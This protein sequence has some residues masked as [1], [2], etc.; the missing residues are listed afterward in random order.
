MTTPSLTST[1]TTS[2]DATPASGQPLFGTVLVANRGEIA[3]RV[4]R[5]LR[6]LGIRSV[7]V[8]SDADAGARHVREAD[9]AVRIGPAAATESYLKIGNIIAAC[10]ESGAEAVHPGYGFLS[11]NADFARALDAAGIAFMGPGVE[12]LNIMGDKIRSKNHVA[13]YG[14]PVVP[15][16]ARPGMTDAELIEAAP[17]VGFP[18]LIKPSAGG[19]GKGMHVVEK[20][21][22]L[23]A[24]LA[25]ARRVAASAFGDDT[26]F[27]ERLVTTPRHIEV[28]VL[29]DSHGNVIHLGERECSLQRRHQKVIEE[30][31][32]P[33]LEGLPHGADVRD[34]IGE[35]ACNA[36]RSVNYTGAGTVEFLVSDDAPDEFFFM[37]MNTRLQVE[38]PVTEMVTGLDLVE[39]QVRIAAGAELTVRQADVELSGHAVEA[40]V[41]AEVPEK[42]FLPSTGTVYLLDELPGDAGGRIRVDSSLV[43]G[44]QLSSS[45]D[46][47]LSKVIAWGADRAEALDTLDRALAG[48]TALGVDTNVEYLRL[49]VNDPEVRAGRLDTGLIARKLP[50]LAFRQVGEVELV[51]A[52]LA[53][54]AVTAASAKAAS[55]TRESN[56]SG[57][58]WQARSGWRLGAPAP[59]RV[60]LGTPDGGVATIALYGDPASG[61]VEV[62]VDGGTRH[63]AVLRLSGPGHAELTLDDAV[64]GFSVAPAPEAPAHIYLGNGGWSCRLE[65]L[66]RE[67][68]LERV[69]AA[70]QRDEGDADPAVRSPMP[71]TVVS[72][73]VKDG[74]AV[75]AGQVLASVEAMK[76]EHQLVAPLAGTVHLA[77]K[78]GDLVKADQVL[79]TI[80]PA[81]RSENTRDNSTNGETTNGEGAQ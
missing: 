52:A 6:A 1:A 31:P 60:S 77:A 24:V 63:T 30:A 41:Y 36:A 29:A 3:C 9:T 17:A 45:Y 22:D 61:P 15:G 33:L 56:S 81:P 14:V 4:I 46:P 2:A 11:E 55:A 71:G 37:E 73:P 67:A 23:P 21:G 78:P 75:E 32:S 54:V 16:V 34:R 76:M 53:S 80:H 62:T 65:V 59:R 49:L 39:W 27:L 70:I 58:P 72:V 48:Y 26:L 12:A 64:H 51:A 7:A 20:P 74:D 8:Y 69:R 18:L 19:G 38:H 57:S 43:E 66:T 28:Q 13:G 10:R 68:R 40:R 35:A 5:T 47:M 79:A 50:G 42:N 44:L 25:T